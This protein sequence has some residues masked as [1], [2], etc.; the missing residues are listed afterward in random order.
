MEICKIDKKIVSWKINKENTAEIKNILD[1]PSNIE[2][3]AAPKRPTS[4]PCEIKKVKV[5]G[6]QWTVFVG[7]LNDKPY[8]LFGGLSKYIEIPNKHK[9]GNIVKNKSS[10]DLVIGNDDDQMTIRDIVSI[11]ENPNYGNLTRMISL[12]LRHGTPIQF[13]VEQLQKD[14][15]SDMTS[16]SRVIGRVLKQYVK[17]G[18][19]SSGEKTCPECKK[20]GSLVYQSGCVMCLAC[21]FS[22]CS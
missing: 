16:F 14:K 12:S 1:R 11:F 22:K 8:E 21:Q 10:Y 4:L 9:Q 19:V 18:T 2:H 6:D 13:I 3:K 20:S 15:N 17:D 7:L 5:Q